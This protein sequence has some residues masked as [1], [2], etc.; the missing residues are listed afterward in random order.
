MKTNLLGIALFALFTFSACNQ[1]AQQEETPKEPVAKTP[2]EVVET[3][4]PILELRDLMAGS[5]SSEKQAESDTDYYAISLYMHPIWKGKGAYLYV[6]QS[7]S[8]MQDKPYRQRV[9]EL[10]QGNDSMFISR[11]YALDTAEKY[12]GKWQEP[13]FFNDLDES[14]LAEREG[15]EVFLAKLSATEY[16]GATHPTA[17]G[18]TLRGASYAVSRLSIFADLIVSWYQGFDSTGAQVWGA[19]KG[20]Y[21]FDRLADQ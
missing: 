7:L 5:F 19:E 2:A 11:V 6:E 12:I 1:T 14:I 4:S 21:I 18:S 13:E 8:S 20:G 16:K 17:C 9:Y 10:E 3:P 15:C